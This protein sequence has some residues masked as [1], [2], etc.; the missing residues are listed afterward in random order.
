MHTREF[1]TRVHVEIWTSRQSS[2]LAS[3]AYGRRQMANSAVNRGVSKRCSVQRSCTSGVEKSVSLFAE[4]YGTGQ[5]SGTAEDNMNV[6]KI[7][8]E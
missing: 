2:T 8:L 6:L 3:A 7:G 5:G 4:T 1:F